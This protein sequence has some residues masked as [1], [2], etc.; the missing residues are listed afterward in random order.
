MNYLL[1]LNKKYVLIFTI[2]ALVIFST[3]FIYKFYFKIEY[4]FSRE[5][6]EVSNADITNPRFAINN[7]SQK[8]FVT[9]KEA[10][11]I[12]DGKILLKT[13]V[14]FTSNNFSIES[15]NVIFDRDGQTA[16]SK[17]DSI[18][19]SDKT[20]ISSEGFDIY[21]NGNKISFYGNA[22]VILK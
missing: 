22:V 19:K 11:F 2:L 21:D 7:P 5:T 18:F 9:A 1:S 3:F 16:H 6:V 15:D 14:K 17:H 12:E 20:I 8:I 4:E 10:N 13:N